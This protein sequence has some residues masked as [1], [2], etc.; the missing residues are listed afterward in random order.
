MADDELKRVSM[1]VEFETQ[2]PVDAVDVATRLSW[3]DALQFCK[4]VDEEMED[5][6]FTLALYDHF[7]ALKAA[8]DKE[9]LE[10]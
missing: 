5:W 2:V 8:H 3:E 1:N 7:A 4:E 10:P 6:D 9:A